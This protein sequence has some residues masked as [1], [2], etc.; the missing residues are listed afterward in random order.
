MASHLW[1]MVTMF[2][3][4]VPSNMGHKL[5]RV[6]PQVLS[7]SNCTGN[8]V[9]RPMV[10]RTL[11]GNMGIGL[12][13]LFGASKQQLSNRHTYIIAS[14]DSRLN[15]NR[16]TVNT[17]KPIATVCIHACLT[18]CDRFPFESRSQLDSPSSV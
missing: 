14:T 12:H 9:N 15:R 2:T 1:V 3:T 7:S 18:I 8:F 13:V 6:M 11:L 10:C 4:N 17:R 5:K 16:W